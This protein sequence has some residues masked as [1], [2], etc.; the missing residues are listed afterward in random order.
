MLALALVLSGVDGR[1]QSALSV[2]ALSL[3]PGEVVVLTLAGVDAARPIRVRAFGR[4]VSVYRDGDAWKAVIGIDLDTKPRLYHAIVEP[5]GESV[6]LK[7][8]PKAFRTR[9]LSVNEAF[10]TPPAS[11]EA[12]IAREAEMMAEAWRH[13]APE[14]LW[15]SGFVRP[16]PHEANSAFGTRSIFNGKRRNPHGGADFLSPA[17]TTVAAPA[18]GRVVIAQDLYYSGNTVII[19][20]GLGVFS[21]LAH[22]SRIDVRPG[23]SIAAGDRVGLVGATGRV[24][25]PHLHWAVRIND[26][27]VDPLSLLRVLGVAK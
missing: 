12:R 18:A 2:N 26:A 10:V 23:T 6:E 1:G 5:G 14:H 11:A 21:M 7:V 8:A 17:G 9:R 15:G 20:H 4:L 22:L 24:T 27:R 13:S 25:G 19:D 3:Q 16:V